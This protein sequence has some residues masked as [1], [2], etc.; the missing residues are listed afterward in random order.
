M[1]EL[2]D[3]HFIKLRLRD[4]QGALLSENFY[5]RSLRDCDY[6]SLAQ[7]PQAALKTRAKM[8][9]EGMRVEIRNASGNIAVG[10]RL[11]AAKAGVSGD[12]RILPAFYDD[13]YFSLLP[14][15]TRE[16]CIRY[17]P[18]DGAHPC[19]VT[20]GFNAPRRMVAVTAE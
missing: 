17:A 4:A 14:G 5:W 8:T 6:T 18:Q 3:T 19:L 13:N 15:E 2:S 10:V 1:P 9:A 7:M 12:D 20:E 16:I 11:K